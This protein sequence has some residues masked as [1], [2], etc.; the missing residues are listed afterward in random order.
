M[1]ADGRFKAQSLKV[2]VLCSSEKANCTV[3]TTPP[4]GHPSNEGK[5]W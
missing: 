5:K 4:F 1:T 3:K 2:S